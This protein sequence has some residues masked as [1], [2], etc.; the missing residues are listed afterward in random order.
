MG[1]PCGTEEGQ[2]GRAPRDGAY[3]F[4]FFGSFFFFTNSPPFVPMLSAC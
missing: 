1:R 4:F 3:F 2:Q